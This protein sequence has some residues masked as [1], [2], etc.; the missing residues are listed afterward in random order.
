MIYNL[1][2]WFPQEVGALLHKGTCR[3]D[4]M[5]DGSC[6]AIALLMLSSLSK[7]NTYM[8]NRIQH[9]NSFSLVAP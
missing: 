1:L 7:V 4:F 6:T 9:L 5:L 3:Q 8:L 2:R